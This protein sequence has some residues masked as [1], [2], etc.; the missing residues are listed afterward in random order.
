MNAASIR[1]SFSTMMEDM[2]REA[3]KV[4][5][6]FAS[7]TPVQ[8]APVHVASSPAKKAP[9]VSHAPVAKAS[10]VVERSEAMPVAAAR[11]AAQV[12]KVPPTAEK[13]SVKGAVVVG[14]VAATAAA[15]ATPTLG[16]ALLAGASA[17]AVAEL[18]RNRK[19]QGAKKQALVAGLT[20]LAAPLGVVYGGMAV[21]SLSG[22][23]WQLG[24]TGWNAA[25]LAILL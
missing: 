23:A 19:K 3:G 21:L 8:A 9:T 22:L 14:V 1:N 7:T 13:V 4:F 17:A 5:R 12:A 25:T 6:R 20:A 10:W 15:I 11:Y 2:A 18:I 16:T 24:L